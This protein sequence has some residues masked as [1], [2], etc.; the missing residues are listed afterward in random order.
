MDRISSLSFLFGGANIL[1]L[2]VGLSLLPETEV[3]VSSAS[4]G[5]WMFA[6][7]AGISVLALILL[8]YDLDLF[9]KIWLSFAFF[10]GIFLFFGAFFPIFVAIPVAVL[11]S[12][13]RYRTS[14]LIWQNVVSL[15]AFSGI[16]AFLGTMLGFLPALI[17]VFALGAYDVFSVNVSKH[18]V[19]LAKK[20]FSSDILLGFAYSAKEG[21]VE[22]L[23]EEVEKD[24]DERSIGFLGG[25]DVII[26]L[27][28]SISV[29]RK[30]GVL[31]AVGS[32]LGSFASLIM[33]LWLSENREGFWPAI[34]VVGGG[35][36]GGLIIV[37][38]IS[39]I[40]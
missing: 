28:F 37:L 19:T 13:V 17:L 39:N 2:L 16:G 31:F 8:K 11:L 32:I 7:I 22:D 12:I 30:F 26:P 1:G 27:I 6:M 40:V 24:S 25:G 10:F 14:S 20:S 21:K 3:Q 38:I 18:M 36:V 33:L 9:L 34:P 5:I 35:A 23:K 15:I 29:L 4:G